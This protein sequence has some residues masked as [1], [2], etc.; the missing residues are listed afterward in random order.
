MLHISSQGIF[1]AGKV[2]DL[3]QLLAKLEQLPISSVAQLVK[4]KLH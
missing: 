4:I 3:Q 2:K 1:F